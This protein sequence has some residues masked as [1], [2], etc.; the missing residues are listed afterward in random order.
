V[1][2]QL[3]VA[4]TGVDLAD[5]EERPAAGAHALQ[6][7]A[8]VRMASSPAGTGS[9]PQR[10]HRHALENSD[11]GSVLR[12]RAP[13]RAIE[14][15]VA[16]REVGD[17]VVLDRGLQQRPLEPGGVARVAAGDAAV[18]HAHPHQHVAA[19]R[20]D[21]AHALKLFLPIAV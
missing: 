11:L 8:S 17:D 2:F 16:Q 15:L 5:G 20:F 6:R 4:G 9:R 10:R 18:D 13:N 1:D 14:R 19:E 7:T 12:D 3:A 21:N